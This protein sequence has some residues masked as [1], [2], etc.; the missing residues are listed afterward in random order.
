MRR[1]IE[2]DGIS[3]G[4]QPIPSGVVIGG[5]LFTGGISGRAP[6]AE[7]PPPGVSEEVAQAFANLRAIL[8]AAGFGPDNVAKITVFT[9]DRSIRDVVNTEWIAMFP[10]P[11]NRPVRH[12]LTQS[13]PG[14]RI[15]LECIAV[16]GPDA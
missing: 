1:V 14:L 13:L 8:D 11:K 9:P 2:V 3:H 10:D 16:A 5:L 7:S 15:Q 12:T 6:W 4:S